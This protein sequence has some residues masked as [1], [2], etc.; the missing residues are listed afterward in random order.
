M[1]GPIRGL[2]ITDNTIWTQG[3][4]SP[5]ALR[6]GPYG[7]IGLSGNLIYRVWS[8]WSGPWPRFDQRGDTVC[9]WEG[10][11]PRLGSSSR[12]DCSPAFAD[13]GHDD[14]RVPDG[15]GVDWAPSE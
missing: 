12:R 5:L 2:R 8:D 4:D 1:F 13:P 6:E 7:R 11:L 10:T 14:Y 9:R 15:A 3:N